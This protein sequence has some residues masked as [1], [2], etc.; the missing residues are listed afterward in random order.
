MDT[1]NFNTGQYRSSWCIRGDNTPGYAEYL[2]YMD[3]W[4]L[5]PDFLEAGVPRRSF[6][7]SS[8]RIHLANLVH[9]LGD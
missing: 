7:K 5:F 8:M 3:F 9:R 1:A 6:E 2:G 4:D